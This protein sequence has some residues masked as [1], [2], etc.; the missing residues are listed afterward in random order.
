MTNPRYDISARLREQHNRLS[1]GTIGRRSGWLGRMRW[2]VILFCCFTLL[3]P[4]ALGA[5]A[6][7]LSP[8]DRFR[9]CPV[10]PEMVVLPAGGFV[11]GS[12]SAE[13]G[14]EPNESPQHR[15]RIPKPFAMGVYEVT[16]DEWDACGRDF[17]CGN[18]GDDE[19]W[20]RERRPVINVNWNDAQE[21]MQWL[22]EKTGHAYRLPS[23]S[24]W[25]YAARAGTVTKYSW[26]NEVGRN[27]ANCAGKYCGDRWA[28]TAPVGSFAPNGFGLHDMH[29]NVCEW[30]EDCW[31]GSY[32]GAPRDGTVWV[33]GDCAKRVLR[34]GSW[35]DVPWDLRAA[36][37]SGLATGY[38]YRFNGFRVARTLAP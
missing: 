13:E 34:G 11:M 16:F 33:G 8:G 30:V 24:E 2:F 12:S 28:N 10:C 9:D 18:F 3:A 14:H 31:N 21:Y 26:G 27:R 4:A 7:G 25:E 22:S 17:A 23:E 1:P 29:G 5:E 20:G 19:G 15:V 36:Y 38:R 35:G 32:G 6:E 37:R